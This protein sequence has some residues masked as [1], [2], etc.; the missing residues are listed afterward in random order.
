M[1]R[2][3]GSLIGGA[4]GGLAAWSYGSLIGAVLSLAWLGSA[5]GLIAGIGMTFALATVDVAPQETRV[6]G[7]LAR[8][9]A[10]R[11]HAIRQPLDV[12]GS[13][14]IPATK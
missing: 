12:A 2:I 3:I 8:P 4:T 6:C 5:V 10:L 13:L 11:G 1:D 9:S 7:S 14:A